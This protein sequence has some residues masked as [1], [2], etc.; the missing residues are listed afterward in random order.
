MYSNRSA[1]SVHVIDLYR[2]TCSDTVCSTKIYLLKFLNLRN[3]GIFIFRPT[4]IA[5]THELSCAFRTFIIKLGPSL[6]TCST[7]FESTVNTNTCDLNTLIQH[8]VQ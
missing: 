8:L 4:K 6:L 2:N 5:C 7:I 1:I 3:G